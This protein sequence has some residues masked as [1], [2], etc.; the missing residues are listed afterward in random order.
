M[1]KKFNI[2]VSEDNPDIRKMLVMRLEI[3]GYN[4]IQAQDGEEA[5]EKIKKYAPDII[6]LDLMMPKISGFE[7]CRMIKFDEKYKGIPII[8][9][10][11]LDQQSDREKAVENGADA[12]FI[13][14]FDLELLLSKIKSFIQKD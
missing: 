8:V 3:N 10:S 4:V 9:L 14:P 11:A 1:D 5:I 2:L 6:I 7:V 13:K 12:Y